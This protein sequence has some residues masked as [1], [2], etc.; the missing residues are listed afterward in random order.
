MANDADL[1]REIDEPPNADKETLRRVE[2]EHKLNFYRGKLFGGVYFLRLVVDSKLPYQP[3][4]PKLSHITL[5]MLEGFDGQSELTVTLTSPDYVELF[6]ALCADLISSTRFLKREDE[7]QALQVVVARIA[8]WRELLSGRRSGV[9]ST[10]KQLGLFGELMILR[11]IFLDRTDAFSAL[12]AWQGPSGAEQDFQFAEWLFEVKSQMASSDRIIRVS[13]EHQ[14]DLKSGSIGLFHQVFS[15]SS[16]NLQDG[17]TLRQ[18][19]EEIQKLVLDACPAAVDLFQARL[20]EVGYEPLAEYNE[21][22]LVLINRSA[23]E[24][25]ETF[26]RIVASDLRVGVNNARYDLSLEACSTFQVNEDYLLRKA[27]DVD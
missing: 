16:E 7:G 8:R 25:T 6:R 11:D 23:Y 22:S 13:S 18:L 19:I 27:F 12:S 2:P 10:K 17:R 9:M 14:L 3:D 1:W 15:T 26:P 21:H 24:V 4:L 20:L 5:T